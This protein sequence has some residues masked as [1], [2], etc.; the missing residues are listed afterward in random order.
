MLG[1]SLKS[2]VQGVAGVAG[3]MGGSA[4]G[5]LSSAILGGGGASAAASASAAVDHVA[6]EGAAR[7]TSL[8][9]LHYSSGVAAA[10]GG[11]W[12]VL[13]AASKTLFNATPLGFQL[14]AYA[15]FM[16]LACGE[17]I[18]LQQMTMNTIR[19]P[20]VTSLSYFTV[21]RPGDIIGDAED[22]A[23]FYALHKKSG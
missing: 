19:V 22:L 4:A 1:E 5:G 6:V 17:P 3:S 20:F 14:T 12:A 23:T 21:Y 15:A 8:H 16:R 10:A 11:A 2:G 13:R 9:P 7:L 18:V